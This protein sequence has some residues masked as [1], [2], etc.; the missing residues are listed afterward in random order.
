MQREDEGL[1]SITSVWVCLI[2]KGCGGVVQLTATKLLGFL[3][4]AGVI[5]SAHAGKQAF[6]I[7]TNCNMSELTSH[8]FCKKNK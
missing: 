8:S 2:Q 5:K 4:K 6:K 3:S 7:I 1:T